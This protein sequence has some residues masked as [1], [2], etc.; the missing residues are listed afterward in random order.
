M[1]WLV[2]RITPDQCNGKREQE[3]DEIEFAPC[4]E[5]AR[6]EHDQIEQQ[7]IGKQQHVV[8]AAGGSEN[9]CEKCA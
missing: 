2:T 9:R 3:A 7:V 6:T 4:L 8:T 1:F 5:P